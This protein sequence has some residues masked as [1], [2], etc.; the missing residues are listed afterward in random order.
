M[1][2]M[3]LVRPEVVT[4]PVASCPK[5]AHRSGSGIQPMS[6]K[7]YA[8]PYSA[9]EKEDKPKKNYPNKAIWRS[10]PGQAFARRPT[11]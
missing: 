8:V 10:N 4:L 9:S 7:I 6:D 2:E 5:I 3:A 1:R 11:L